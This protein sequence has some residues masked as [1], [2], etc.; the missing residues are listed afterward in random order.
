MIWIFI[1]TRDS[2]PE[3]NQ[4][5]VFVAFYL[6]SLL[7][8]LVLKRQRIWLSTNHFISVRF[9][10]EIFRD[11]WPYPFDTS[12]RIISRKIFGSLIFRL[13]RIF[14]TAKGIIAAMRRRP[15]SRNMS[16]RIKEHS[17]AR[18]MRA[19]RVRFISN[20]VTESVMGISEQSFDHFTLYASRFLISPQLG[21]VS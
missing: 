10:R 8:D 4:S 7:E 21:V 19:S 5:R 17:S 1:W 11:T 3:L 14:Q 6:K 12:S 15:W 16:V 20:P 2:H 13:L 9:Q 18:N